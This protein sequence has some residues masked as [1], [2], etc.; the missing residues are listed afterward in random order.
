MSYFANYLASSKFLLQFATISLFLVNPSKRVEEQSVRAIRID[1]FGVHKCGLAV[2]D[3]IQPVCTA[4]H[5]NI[6]SQNVE[7]IPNM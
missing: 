1:H 6:E 3:R 2:V 5:F 7:R 4:L